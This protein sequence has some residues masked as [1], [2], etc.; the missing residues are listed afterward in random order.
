MLFQ[1]RIF[2]FATGRLISAKQ[3]VKLIMVLFGKTQDIAPLPILRNNEVEKQQ[4][5]WEK[6]KRV[7]GWTPRVSLEDGLKKTIDWY[8]AH[9][10]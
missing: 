7:L 1:N 8:R 10:V 6:A 4:V 5:T 2:N 9:Y 3:L